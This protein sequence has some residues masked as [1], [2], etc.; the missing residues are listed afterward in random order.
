MANPHWSINKKIAEPYHWKS[1]KGEG[2]GVAIESG[3]GAF[4]FDCKDEATADMLAHVL[5]WG[6]TR[7][8]HDKI[9]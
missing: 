7:I 4:N 1:V 8:N 5:N 6:V 3:K 2:Y 9:E